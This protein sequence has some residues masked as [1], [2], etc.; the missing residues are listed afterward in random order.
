MRRILCYFLVSQ[1]AILAV[2]MQ[3]AHAQSSVCLT[4][5]QNLKPD[6]LIQGSSF[7]KFSQIQQLVGSSTFASWGNAS[8]SSLSGGIDIPGVVDV[9]LGTKSNASNWGENRSQFLSM[10][11]QL[12]YSAGAGNTVISQTSVAALK[13]IAGCAPEN[14]DRNGFS[15]TLNTVSDHRDSFALLLT[16]RTNGDP[17]WKLIQLSA[18]P[19]DPQ[20]KCNDSL[21]EASSTNQKPIGT[22]TLL[23]NCSKDPEK[24]FTLGIQTTAGAAQTAFTITSVHEEIQKLRDDTTAQIQDLATKLDKHGLVVAFAANTCPAPWI[25]YQPAQGRFI[26]GL[27]PSG[28]NDPDGALRSFGSVQTDGIAN[29]TH[30]MGVSGA[31]STTMTPGTQRLPN[32]VNDRFGAGGKKETDAN[33]NGITETRPKNVALLYCV[34]P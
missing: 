32:F 25:V 31:D 16:N 34:L 24:H 10:S 12:A 15:V 20:F 9:S 6:V 11:S 27:D 5:A 30:T 26:R 23:I 18:Q 7:E 3:E 14:A 8:N 22:Q 2:F 19:P 28:A 17:N 13:V 4:L 29:H 33:T 21:E 1:L